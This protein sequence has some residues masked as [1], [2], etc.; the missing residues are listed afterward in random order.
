MWERTLTVGSAGKA[1]GVTGWKIGWT[2]GPARFITA[3]QMIQQNTV[4]TV[5]TPLQEAL[6]C[7]IEETLP[8]VGTKDCF[9][10]QLALELAAKRDRI[11][12]A[13]T[14]VGMHPIIPQAGFFM[15]ADISGVSELFASLKS[16]K[17]PSL[18]LT[19]ICRGPR[20]WR[21]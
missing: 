3:M 10:D 7:T 20:S 2:I 15:L 21:G 1:F 9:F 17:H 18:T 6:A 4:Y 16:I 14:T 12:R 19:S 13:L 11:A 5:C 8:T